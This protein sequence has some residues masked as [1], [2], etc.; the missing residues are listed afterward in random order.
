MP[1]VTEHLQTM[2]E[3]KEN[4]DSK[5]AELDRK[6]AEADRNIDKARRGKVENHVKLFYNIFHGSK[7]PVPAEQIDTLFSKYLAN[8]SISFEESKRCFKHSSMTRII[9]YLK[10]HPNV[11][12]CDFRPSS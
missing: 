4:L 6:N 3:L 9:D 7:Q 10:E 5:L 8:G 2:K 1:I 11:K 12:Q